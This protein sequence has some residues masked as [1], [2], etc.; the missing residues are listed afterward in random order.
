MK[1]IVI[2]SLQIKS[3]NCKKHRLIQLSYFHAS[4]SPNAVSYNTKSNKGNTIFYCIWIYLKKELYWILYEG[5]ISSF[6]YF[7]LF[8]YE[9]NFRANMY[10][11]FGVWFTANFLIQLLK[12]FCITYMS[13]TR[14]V[15]NKTFQILRSRSWLEEH[16]NK[17]ITAANS[18]LQ[19]SGKLNLF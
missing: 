6:S 11:S 18:N 1:C 13:W 16:T 15:N 10:N 12:K 2:R 17:N 14:F 5:V 9:G 3:T 19:I 7:S 8:K 4:I